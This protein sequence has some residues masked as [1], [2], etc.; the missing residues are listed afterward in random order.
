MF[1]VDQTKGLTLIE[2]WEGLTP[3]DIKAC[4]GADFEVNGV[5]VCHISSNLQITDGENLILSS[6]SSVWCFLG[7]SKPE[8]HAAN[9]RGHVMNVKCFVDYLGEC[10]ICFRD[11]SIDQ[12]TERMHCVLCLF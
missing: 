4:T 9:L 5:G 11:R 3:E 7:V 6:L 8:D 12:G 1:D 2:L 10:Q